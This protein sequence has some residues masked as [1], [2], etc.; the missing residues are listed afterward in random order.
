MP[1]GKFISGYPIFP[2]GKKSWQ[3]QSRVLSE[4]A[5]KLPNLVFDFYAWDDLRFVSPERIFASHVEHK[6]LKDENGEVLT[7]DASSAAS[8]AGRQAKNNRFS[9]A[10]K[11]IGASSSKERPPKKSGVLKPGINTAFKP[12]VSEDFGTR[13]AT[14]SL[15]EGQS[16]DNWNN[17]Y[18][19]NNEQ[20]VSLTPPAV[21][22]NA[23]QIPPGRP[24]PAT[25][26]HPT[27]PGG[28]GKM[29]PKTGQKNPT[30]TEMKASKYTIPCPHPVV[31]HG[32][33]LLIDRKLFDDLC[34][35]QR[36]SGPK[37]MF[38]VSLI[39]PTYSVDQCEENHPVLPRLNKPDMDLVC[40]GAATLYWDHQVGDV[41]DQG[42]PIP[43]VCIPYFG[44]IFGLRGQKLGEIFMHYILETLSHTL[45]NK[46][47]HFRAH[48]EK[49][50]L[51]Q[52]HN[53]AT[54]LDYI[55]WRHTNS[56]LG[57]F[58]R[59]VSNKRP[60]NR[61][62]GRV[63]ELYLPATKKAVP[64]WQKMG[65]QLIE[66]LNEDNL[67]NEDSPS[68][69]GGD[70]NNA[71]QIKKQNIVNYA[72][73]TL[74]LGTKNVKNDPFKREHICTGQVAEEMHCFSQST[75]Q[76]FYIDY[77]EVLERTKI[78]LL[79]NA[80]AL[81][82]SF[83]TAENFWLF[84]EESRAR[85]ARLRIKMLPTSDVKKDVDGWTL[86]HE[87]AQSG[88]DTLVDAAV[89]R[90]V[91]PQSPDHEWKQTPIFYSANLN[92]CD[93]IA[94]MIKAG[95]K[96]KHYDVNGQP[97][98]FYAAKHN[99]LEAA[100]MFVEEHGVSKNTRDACRRNAFYYAQQSDQ[101]GSHAEMMKLLA[102]EEDS[103]ESDSSSDEKQKKVKT[104]NPSAR[105]AA[106]R[107]QQ[108]QQ[109]RWADLP[110]CPSAE[111]QIKHKLMSGGSSSALLK[112]SGHAAQNLQLL[113][114][115][116]GGGPPGGV[117]GNNR[118]GA[119]TSGSSSSSSTLAG[120]T[121]AA[122]RGATSQAAAAHAQHQMFLQHKGGSGP[123]PGSGGKMNAAAGQ[124]NF[125]AQQ[126]AA[127]AQHFAAHHKGQHYSNY[128]GGGQHPQY[129]S[130]AAAVQQQQHNMLMK[131]GGPN[132]AQKSHLPR[133]NSGQ[134]S[135]HVLLPPPP[136][137]NL[138]GPPRGPGSLPAQTLLPLDDGISASA[139]KL[140]RPGGG[141]NQNRRPGMGGKGGNKGK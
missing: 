40:I 41:D 92:K 29:N 8:E 80:A 48:E 61:D 113:T 134:K 99:S 14:A 101:N 104:R 102:V 32:E 59:L 26:M 39:V 82:S 43:S 125:S 66:V 5:Q 42:E 17:F 38:T 141:M 36:R 20:N 35:W 28:P 94:I 7:L 116:G 57:K 95:A 25:I 22:E 24:T 87:A 68:A 78:P 105:I 51:M 79:P 100:K 70:N 121:S 133:T 53:L 107:A 128:P 2:H 34:V 60:N 45:W 58:G 85:E 84:R 106:Q 37:A 27:I 103:D 12:D 138:G 67:A 126:K 6:R 119:G 112:P 55:G 108:E 137:L 139:A 56:H 131:G 98:L 91:D 71:T 69:A 73:Q 140:M 114:K 64:F 123:P 132:A 129:N 9:V 117:A 46:E 77:L 124:H 72:D 52:E 63:C 18:G 23:D 122:G 54:D 97:A 11:T 110:Y 127:A 15:L 1:Q 130:H 93:A 65:G 75:T 50:S 33:R 83:L 109:L 120:G 44:T 62:E 76:L 136:N 86:L 47:A 13:N 96:A 135:S 30:I 49:I 89:R 90:R 115:G 88:D 16:P 74:V 31:E 81:H 118:T 3:Y 21:E 4:A 111:A 19:D 10:D